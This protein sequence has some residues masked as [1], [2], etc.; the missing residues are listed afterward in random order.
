M[1]NL[2]RILME[3]E[4]ADNIQKQMVNITRNE[5]CKKERKHFIYRGKK[6]KNYTRYFFRNH[7]NKKTV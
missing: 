1:I 5:N 4:K 3:K 2:S 7:T 6:D